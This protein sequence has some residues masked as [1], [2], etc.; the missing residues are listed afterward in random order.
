MHTHVH[1]VHFFSMFPEECHQ[2]GHGDH[3]GYATGAMGDVW[4]LDILDV[5][6]FLGK[7]RHW[8]LGP[9][10]TARVASHWILRCWTDLS[11]SRLPRSRQSVCHSWLCL[12]PNT[13]QKLPHM[14][15]YCYWAPMQMSGPQWTSEPCHNI[16]GWQTGNHLWCTHSCQELLW[17]VQQRPDEFSLLQRVPLNKT[18]FGGEFRVMT[19]GGP[20]QFLT[21]TPL[22]PPPP[23]SCSSSSSS[24]AG[25]QSEYLHCCNIASSPLC[26]SGCKVSNDQRMS[27]FES[28][29]KR[30]GHRSLERRYWLSS[31]EPTSDVHLFFCAKNAGNHGHSLFSIHQHSKPIVWGLWRAHCMRFCKSSRLLAAYLDPGI[32]VIS[33]FISSGVDL[34]Q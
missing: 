3:R 32:L 28:T 5:I 13:C 19:L 18:G 7:F 15:G 27:L 1:W 10:W 17:P 30:F 23:S 14:S 33:N 22:P 31:V 8:V 24:H 20:W 26:R 21:L 25:V 9:F 4:S 16:V 11:A 2:A 29:S 34:Q 12:L 6:C